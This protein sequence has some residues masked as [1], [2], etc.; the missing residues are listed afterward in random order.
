MLSALNGHD[1]MAD[2]KRTCAHFLSPLSIDLKIK[3]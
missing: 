1:E 2:A 3:D